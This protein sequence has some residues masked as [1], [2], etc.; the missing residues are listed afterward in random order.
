MPS[1]KVRQNL[2]LVVGLRGRFEEAKKIAAADLPENEAAANVNY[3][4]QMFAQQRDW[5][6]MGRVYAPTNDTGS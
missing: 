2:A 3:L 6:K 4:R 1:P 5:K